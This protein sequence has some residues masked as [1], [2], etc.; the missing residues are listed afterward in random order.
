MSF[1]LKSPRWLAFFV[2]SFIAVMGAG[3][4]AFEEETEEPDLMPDFDLF[5]QSYFYLAND[6]D[7]DRTEPVYERNGQ[8]VGY[9]LTTFR[10]GLTWVPID[11]VT[12]RYQLEVGDNVWSRNDLDGQDPAAQNSSVVRH[13]QVWAEV[14]TPG[15]LLG[16]KTGYQYFYDP[17]HLVID[18]HMG[19]AQAFFQWSSTK[20]SM[21]A[22]QVPD[23]VYEGLSATSDGDR[24]EQNN[25]EQDD[26]I[27]AL[28]LDYVCPKGWHFSPG[29]FF[30]WD[31]TEI[32]R[33]KGVLSAVFNANGY[34]GSRL[35]MDFDAVGQYGQ[36]KNGGLSNRDVDYLAAAAQV[37]ALIDLRP[38]SLRY[39]ALVF[40]ADDGD[41]Y[42]QY[43]TG[44]HYS[45]W[46]K[47]RTM[48][49]S[50]N[51]LHD[52]YDNL[53]ERVAAQGA[54]LALFDQ[55]ASLALSES[56][57][58]LTIVG[59]GLTLDGTHTNDSTYLGTEGHVGV[60]WAL[61]NRHVAFTLLGGGLLPGEAA[62]VVKNKIDREKTDSL[63]VLQ[64]AMNVQF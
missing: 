31:K 39:N 16:I 14:L 27:F 26:Y 8:S 57:Q 59:V 32:G 7:F 4:Y 54:G 12:L 47:S 18:R 58:L 9:M 44:F 36:Y 35:K 20:V 60:E 33:P 22:G 24:T 53:D 49:M 43:D 51:W 13:K 25:F 63:G 3:A 15:G 10:P 55:G 45:G 17:T 2:F 30:R 11:N 62:A 52:Q 5:F 21:A 29:A 61:Y 56:V 41:K 37:G 19:L 48:V 1:I 28:W 46:S 38:F 40:T 34:F 6:S 50:L 23:T 42:D 64:A